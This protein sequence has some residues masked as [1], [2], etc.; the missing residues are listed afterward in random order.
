MSSVPKKEMIAKVL[1]INENKLN[2]NCIIKYFKDSFSLVLLSESAEDALHL[3][4]KEPLDLV[5]STIDY[6][7]PF[8]IDFFSVVRLTMGVIPLI[9]ITNKKQNVN[10][11]I[12]TNIG[13]DDVI[14][15]DVSKEELFRKTES[16]SEA[17]EK[18]CSSLPIKNALGNQRNKIVFILANE[19]LKIFDKSFLKNS[20]IRYINNLDDIDNYASADIFLIDSGFK[21]IENNCMRLRL[22]KA[23]RHKPILLLFDEDKQKAISIFNKK[24]GITDILDKNS[25]PLIISCKINAHI[26]YKRLLEE[27]YRNVKKNIYLSSMDALTEVYNRGF[28]EEYINGRDYALNHSAVLMIDLDKFKEINDKYGHTFADKVLREI[29]K[30]IKNHIRNTD[31]VIRY[32]GDEFLVLMRNTSKQEVEKIA[33]RLVENVKL[34]S[35]HGISCTVSVGACCIDM[36]KVKLREAIFVA[37]S[38]M[39]ISKQEGGNSVHICG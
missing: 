15:T 31:L 20:Q 6:K 23:S 1:I 17:K 35:F 10:F 4:S 16:L 39:Y 21:Q 14:F 8:P 26:K 24:V 12:L 37:D 33:N 9:G 19:E 28:L 2:L 25:N 36:E 11:P 34:S 38:F 22:N 7:N 32:G 27:F 3:I 18:M 13:I 5:L 30:Q 29:A